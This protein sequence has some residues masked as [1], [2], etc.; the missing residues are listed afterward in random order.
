[1]ESVDARTSGVDE[2]K[3][4]PLRNSFDLVLVF[5]QPLIETLLG[6]LGTFICQFGSDV[7]GS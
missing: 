7:G 4:T 5:Q 1:M 6:T 3:F 2:L